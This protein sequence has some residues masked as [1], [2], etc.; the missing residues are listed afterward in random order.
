MWLLIAEV[1]MLPDNPEYG[2][3][4]V[5]AWVNGWI[6]RDS[7]DEALT[8]AKKWVESSLYKIVCVESLKIVTRKQF[9]QDEKLQYFEQA[10]IDQEVFVFY[11]FSDDEAI[12]DGE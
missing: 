1:E 8:V 5:Q 11:V 6:V 3:L 12:E 10:L 9:E 4:H 7:A 2:R